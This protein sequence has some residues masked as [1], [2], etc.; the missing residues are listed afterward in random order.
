LVVKVGEDELR[1]HKPA[2]YQPAVAAVYDRRPPSSTNLAPVALSSGPQ[3]RHSSLVTRHCS[4]VLASNNEVAFRVAG[5]DPKRALVIDPVLTY[6]TY[7]GGSSFDNGYGIAADS[8]GN[9][10]VTGQTSSSDFPTA[11]PLQAC[12][13]RFG[14]FDAFV[15][16]LNAAGSAL[17]YSTYLGGSNPNQGNGIAVDSSGNA[18]V[19]GVTYSYDFPTVNPFQAGNY[20]GL[21]GTAFVA[22]LNATGS[23]L[24]YSTY[25]GGSRGGDYGQGIAADSAGNAY[26]TGFT[27]QS[28]F[29]TVNPLQACCAGDAFVTKL[30][31]A[32]SALVY[33][34]YLGGSDDWDEGLGIAADSSGN[35]YV[36]GYT[37]ST[38][39]PTVNPIQAAN[40]A[41]PT[42]GLSTAFVAKLNSTGSALVYS[43]Y[44]GGSY[45]DS[46]RGIAADSSGN[47]YV[48][49]ETG[50]TDFPTVN[51]LQATNKAALTAGNST[52]FVAKLNSTGSALV[53]S[54]YLGGSYDDIGFGIAAD[55]SGNAYVTGA[56]S[57]TDFPTANP[58]Q[59]SYAGGIC[60]SPSMY[61][62]C[63][64]AFVTKLDPSGSALVYS[65]YLGG[66]SADSGSGI[67]VDSSGNAYVT[68]STESTDFPTVNP[69]QAYK[70]TSVST[71]FV[72]ELSPTP[73]PAL[74]FSANTVN[75]GGVVLN[76]TSPQQSVTITD[77][78][79]APLGITGIIASGDFALVTTATSC[80]YGGG[81]LASEAKCT[82]D[83]T[84]TPTALAVRTGA[85]TVTD[86]ASGSPHTVQLSG[87]G[88]VSAAHVSATTLN[89]LYQSVGM[90]SS[91]QP[92]TL[93]NTASVVL[94]ISN[95][96]ISSG[97]TQ[98]NNCL[99]SVGPNA[100]CTVN[101]SFQPTAVGPYT[102]TLTLTDYAANSPQT[103]NLTG[104]GVLPPPNVSPTS[105][106]FNSQLVGTTSTPQ[107]VT[108][109]NTG[110][111]ALSISILTIS[112]GFTQSNNCLPFVAANA[113]C[114]IN[115]SFSPTAADSGT[116]ALRLTDNALNSPQTIAL[117]G[118][119]QDFTLAAASGSSTS[120]TVAPGQPATYT[121]SAAGE[122]GF[123]QSVS[124]TCTGAPSEAT[125]TVPT[126]VTVGSSATNITV[127]VTTTAPSASAP[128]FRPL[129]PVPPLSPALRGLLMLALA[130]AAMAWA[131]GHRTQPGV[132]RWRSTIVL[133]AWGLLLTLALAGCGGSASVTHN[134]GTPPGT[135]TLTVTGSTGSGSATL[136][137]SVTLTLT[138]S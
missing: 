68:G 88:S 74:S 44:L 110:T 116:G 118:T 109:T 130:F 99:P 4:F 20:S 80:P 63:P 135:Y 51:P 107:P 92:V 57:S 55:S 126:P 67:A 58:L 106:I 18:Y 120:V 35:A 127:S 12:A 111:L 124:F 79:N 136:S 82:I 84:F 75:F 10:Y 112:S 21:N 60:G 78:G 105:L 46:G 19:T 6:S 138:V 104:T 115:V 34:T 36:T 131:I 11:N 37:H 62:P 90:A 7:L 24:V 137:H 33:S 32:G 129:P 76:T 52:A 108:V 97:W 133:L 42:T 53:Y 95:L 72:A 8:S 103:V 91:P 1:F 31:A 100:S 113:S 77:L 2:V 122:G 64:D 17:V 59:G 61:Y 123:N 65:T 43:T 66:S 25:L 134:P 69:L 73:A 45:Y 27:L 96:T 101:V 5:Y 125:C 22:K 85:L 38:D 48:T 81:T 14:C 13:G 132:S 15:T 117:S 30:N 98:S 70:A 121:L 39:F 26:V 94:T 23:A 9:A 47:A 93:T 28:D 3:A 114:T 50:S 89:F 29:P 119:G 49:G 54:T 83:V 71:A 86:N 87:T 41:T 102:G 16:K 56:T 40:K 128:R